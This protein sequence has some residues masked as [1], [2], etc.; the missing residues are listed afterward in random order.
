MLKRKALLIMAAVACLLCFQCAGT[1]NG[2]SADDSGIGDEQVFGY[3]ILTRLPGL[4]NGP[5]S[6]TTPAGSF[7]NWYVDFRPVSSGQVSQYSTLDADTINYLSFFIVKHDGQLKVAL[8][9]EGVFQNKGCVTYEVIDKVRESEGY[10]RFSDF[11]AKDGRAYTEF[12]FKDD[13]FVM[14]VFTNKF[15]RVSPLE[16]HSRWDA[17]LGDKKA[18]VDTVSAIGYPKPEMIKD[19]SFVFQHMSESIFYTFENDPYSSSDQPYVGNV[20]VNISVDENLSVEK[21][22]ELFLLLTT[23]SLF[24]GLKYDEDNMRY[25][26]RYVFLPSGTSSYTFYNVHPGT[27]FLYSYNDINNDKRH[28]SG[29]FMSS[30]LSNTFTVGPQGSIT[31]NTKIDFVIP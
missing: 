7:E 29:D 1:G 5:V 30:D 24:D 20:T 8:R 17:K 6:T 28:L 4:W 11:K 27:Y 23:E 21:D 19:F 16:L 2:I 15:N 13:E 3:G 26:S 14:E 31:V 9:T 12:T 22:H 25:I 18:A 10:Y